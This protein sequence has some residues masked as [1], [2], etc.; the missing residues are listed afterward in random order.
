[1]EMRG[2]GDVGATDEMDEM[3]V[4]SKVAGMGGGG[5]SFES[6]IQSDELGGS[7]FRTKRQLT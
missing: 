7:K 4:G 3:V 2:D 5:M 1:M 6:A